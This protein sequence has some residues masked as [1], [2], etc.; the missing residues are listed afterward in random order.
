MEKNS[1]KGLK[2]LVLLLLLF[3]GL[4]ASVTAGAYWASS[5]TAADATNP[6][7]ELTV[8]IGKG[9]VVEL[10]TKLD[11]GTQENDGV[12]PLVPSDHIVPGTTDRRVITIRADWAVAPG[13]NSEY[14]TGL[15]TVSGTLNA[16]IGTNY[17]LFGK[18]LTSAEQTAI[19]EMFT[20]EVTTIDV[21]ITIGGS[22]Y[23]E[24]TIIFENEPT[25]KAFYDLVAEGQLI[26]TIT[27]SVVTN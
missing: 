4:G 23:I 8:T 22:S 5:F 18:E 1:N 11:L 13:V 21:P 19:N 25:T 26:I 16:E 2:K 6:N 17:S 14:T 27:L 20:V 7:G 15:G 9:G 24:V 12:L 10:E 3:V